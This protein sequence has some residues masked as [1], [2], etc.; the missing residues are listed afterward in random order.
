MRIKT[1]F[2]AI[3]PLAVAV[4]AAIPGSA[5]VVILEE[6]I[7]KV[8]GDIV[9]RS[10]YDAS[11]RELRAEIDRDK[12]LADEQKAQQL[13]QR[14]PNSLRNLIDN[15]LLI[16]RA[17]DLNINVEAQVLRQRDEIM[18][19][20]KIKTIDE[21]ENWIMEETGQ[22]AEDLLDRMRNNF[23]SQSVMGQEVGSR[24]VIPR[25]DIEAYYEEHKEEFVRSEGIHLLEIFISTEAKTGAELEAAKKK[26]A[27]V[28]KRVQRGEPFREMAKRHSEN[29]ET[30]AAGGDIG[31]WQRGQL[32]KEI[33]DVVFAA[34]KGFI[35]DLIESGNGLLILRVEDKFREGQATLEEAQEE[36]RNQLAGPKFEPAVREYMTKLR[37]DAYIEIRPGYMD[38]AAAA[39]KDTSWSDPAKLMP[40]TTTREEVLRKKKKRRLLWVIPLPG[41]GDKDKDKKKEKEA[42][43]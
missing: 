7:A 19:Q 27:D 9:L 13:K 18:R 29:E 34:N 1:V 40:V 43:D 14:E 2:L 30:A 23:L 4:L 39:G 12:Q 15:R 31:I 36:I 38:T 28:H 3:L 8:N 20:Y 37:Q 33:E 35:S 10:E 25:A 26:A 41:G 42:D 5:D 22:P 16:Q 11:I 24:I 6:I 17:K 21:F 32:R